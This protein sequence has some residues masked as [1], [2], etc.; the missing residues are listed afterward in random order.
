[1]KKIIIVA[2]LSFISFTSYAVEPN[3]NLNEDSTHHFS[4]R[5]YKDARIK[6]FQTEET[7]SVACPV[8]FNLGN[9]QQ[10]RDVYK[11]IDLDGKEQINGYGPWVENSRNCHRT[12]NQSQT[13]SCPANQSGSWIQSRSYTEYYNGSIINDTGWRDSTKTCDYYY[14]STG[15]DYNYLA[16][17]D[18]YIGSNIQARSYQLY[19][20]NSRRN[21]SGWYTYSY[22]CAPSPKKSGYTFL[23]QTKGVGFGAGSQSIAMININNANGQLLC[24]SISSFSGNEGGWITGD[25]VVGNFNSDSA[26]CSS[27]GNSATAV[28]NCNSTSGGDADMCLSGT[29]QVNISSVSNNGCIVTY[30]RR[31][32]NSGSW[33]TVSQN[34]CQ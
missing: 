2:L 1:M 30:Q 6:P 8:P 29:W 20:D 5:T 19:S 9:I 16:C 10:R 33:V 31:Y 27:S 21:Y 11:A 12:V 24:S 34:I 28:G 7:Q 23:V 17:P 32:N 26:S 14:L 15:Y 25:V 18:G 13:L 22:T 3:I 4:L